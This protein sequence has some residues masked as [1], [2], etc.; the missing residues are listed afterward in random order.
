MGWGLELC[1]IG[2]V[3]LF[4]L[5]SG[6]WIIFSL[7][8]AGMVGIMLSG[9]LQ[10][11][12]P[13][14]YVI[15]NSCNNFNLTAIP[16]FILM[17]ELILQSG[18][19]DKFYR[20]LG[21]WFHR[22]PGGLLQVNIMASA[23]F[24][25]LTGVSV[26]SAA[27]LGTVAIPSQKKQG[28]DHPM[29][30]GSLTGGGALAILIPP[31]IPL[32]IYGAM[33]ENSI[34][35]LFMAG[36]IPGL[37]LSALFMVYIFVRVYMN[38][39]LTPKEDAIHPWQVKI[40]GLKDILPILVI[41]LI[42]LLG[43]YYGLTTPTE[44]GAVG[45]LCAFVLGW[46]NSGKAWWVHFK[47]ALN[48]SI[49]TTCMLLSIMVGAQ[50]LAFSLVSTGIN[51][52]MTEWIVSFQ[53]PKYG[54]LA[55]VYIVYLILGCFMDPISIL[56][57]TL[58]IVYPIITALGFSPIWFG[59]ILVVLIEIGLL[60]PPVGMNLFII[61]GISGGSSFEDVVHGS[62]PYIV[63]MILFLVALSFFQF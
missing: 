21:I 3:L 22:I 36:I 27:A 12:Q 35:K 42:V 55:A 62:I 4:L 14:G 39:A 60:T 34:V 29:I 8:I 61:H 19:S 16:L 45:A 33:T 40:A 38:P 7:G 54:F 41:A 31:S 49:K 9:G 6:Q 56:L 10:G 63:I 58:P 25:S 37:I 59:I 5:A 48:N 57:L 26:A 30:F 47:I 43:I 17:G 52:D 15:W 11:L 13:L 51:R 44:A 28:Y 32:I 1:L 18:V 46:Y 50:I 53:L 23:L 20:S 24:A 2:L